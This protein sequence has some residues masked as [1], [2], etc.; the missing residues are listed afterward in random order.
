M[1]KRLTINFKHLFNTDRYRSFQHTQVRGFHLKLLKLSG[2][3]VTNSDHRAQMYSTL[4][5][6]ECKH[7]KLNS[8]N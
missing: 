7:S 2:C 8:T 6:V 5:P 1:L 3:E 4:V